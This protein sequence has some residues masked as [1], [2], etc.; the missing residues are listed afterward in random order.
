MTR[1]DV[2]RMAREAGI[3]FDPA[4]PGGDGIDAWYGDQYLPCGA[5]VKLIEI[6][7]AEERERNAKCESE[8]CGKCYHQ[9]FEEG[10]AAERELCIED[11]RTVGGSFAIECEDLI[12][13]RGDK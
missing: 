1:D 6:A 12:R 11:A 8:F 13:A 5:V 9:G 4:A 7:M 10:V 3:N 2:I